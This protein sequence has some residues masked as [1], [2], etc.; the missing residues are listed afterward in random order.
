[1]AIG[2]VTLALLV[3]VLLLMGLS[4]TSSLIQVGIFVIGVATWIAVGP[5]TPDDGDRSA[6]KVRRLR[7]DKGNVNIER[8]GKGPVSVT[9]VRAGEDIDI[10]HRSNP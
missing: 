9:D 4:V 7:A 1:M 5:R 8:E 3:L 2:C 6:L 10:T